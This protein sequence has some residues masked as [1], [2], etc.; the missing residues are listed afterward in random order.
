MPPRILSGAFVF[1]ATFFDFV[2]VDFV[3]AVGKGA[4]LEEGTT[5]R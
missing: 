4:W 5:M 1:I 2:D 3:V